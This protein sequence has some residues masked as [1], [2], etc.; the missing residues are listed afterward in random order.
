LDVFAEK[1]G[2]L[3]G[4]HWCKADKLT[5]GKKQDL[6]PAPRV[7]HGKLLVVF[8]AVPDFLL[9]SKITISY[10]I[11]L[12]ILCLASA[13]R[14]HGIPIRI[15]TLYPSYLFRLFGMEME[16]PRT[17]AA[18]NHPGIPPPHLCHPEGSSRSLLERC[19]GKA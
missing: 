5:D 8:D 19:D 2:N 1:K 4:E 7:H 15:L 10:L 14:V 16:T 18:P 3:P 13:K 12:L 17:D 11:S 9:E 6:P